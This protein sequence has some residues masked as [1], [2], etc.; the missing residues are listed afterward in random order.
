[1]P[2][3]LSGEAGNLIDSKLIFERGFGVLIESSRSGRERIWWTRTG[4]K[5]LLRKTR[6][7]C[8]QLI[9]TRKT[10]TMN[11]Y[12]PELQN[13]HTA[14]YFC[15]LNNISCGIQTQ[16]RTLAKKLQQNI[17][18]SIVLFS[19]SCSIYFPSVCLN[20]SSSSFVRTILLLSCDQTVTIA[21]AFV[22]PSTWRGRRGKVIW[23]S[24]QKSSSSISIYLST[25]IKEE[26][27]KM[28]AA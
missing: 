3:F 11:G 8:C 6:E 4:G 28:Q 2:F 22:F 7:K 25:D 5:Y 1:M 20:L 24:P 14:V 13:R 26:E 19:L 23:S 9:K 18:Q 12:F 10:L 17:F 21:S 27:K 16:R 15:W